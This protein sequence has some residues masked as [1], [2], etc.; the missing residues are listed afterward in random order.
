MRR[1]TAVRLQNRELPGRVTA[2]S[3]LLRRPKILFDLLLS[4]RDNLRRYGK[5]GMA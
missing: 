5:L 4:L 1:H 3:F 2:N